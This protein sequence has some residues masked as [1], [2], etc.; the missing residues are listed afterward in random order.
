[1]S[2]EDTRNQESGHKRRKKVKKKKEKKL[3]GTEK[4]T[5]KENARIEADDAK[6]VFDN[7]SKRNKGYHSM[8]SIEYVTVP[9]TPEKFQELKAPEKEE[10][11]KK[12]RRKKQINKSRKNRFTEKQLLDL[13]CPDFQIK[14]RRLETLKRLV[15]N[16]KKEKE[17]LGRIIRRDDEFETRHE[18]ELRICEL[19]NYVGLLPVLSTKHMNNFTRRFLICG[20]KGV[21]KYGITI[22]KKKKWN[23]NWKVTKWKFP[24][25]AIAQKLEIDIHRCRSFQ[26]FD[27]EYLAPIILPKVRMTAKYKPKHIRQD[28]DH[29]VN[30]IYHGLPEKA[31]PISDGLPGKLR[32]KCEDIVAGGTKDQLIG[33]FRNFVKLLNDN[34]HTAKVLEYSGVEM[35]KI[36]RE[37]CASTIRYN[38]EAKTKKKALSPEEKK[39]V[40]SMIPDI[41]DD[42]KYLGGFIFIPQTAEELYEHL[43]DITG[44]CAP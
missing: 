41:E 44:M 10:F 9:Q 13:E 30:S 22:V 39:Q 15:W 37:K 28:L 20:Y 17:V 38:R 8:D 16:Q 27:L 14:P 34:G 7:K 1:M 21:E 19:F 33:S 5:D 26:A 29:Y 32:S 3:K 35:R 6:R 36:C 40:E 24:S 2:S 18:A 23:Y 31:K 25:R 12:Q 4:K 11:R 42:E 43:L